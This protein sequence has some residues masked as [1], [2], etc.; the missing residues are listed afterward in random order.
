MSRRI[1]SMPEFSLITLIGVTGAGKTTFCRKRFLPSQAL[2][3]DFFR[4]LVADNEN[5]MEASSDAFETLYSVVEKRLARQLLTVIDATNIQDYA[6]DRILEIARRFDAPTV[7]LVFDVPE[8]VLIKRTILRA[9]RP[10]GEEV[11]LEH[12]VDFRKT[13]Q[14]LPEEG[15]DY[16][17]VLNGVEEVNE[18]V[19]AYS[20][21]SP[22]DNA[23]ERFDKAEMINKST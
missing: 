13:I 10:F 12:L 23:L 20:P 7:A 4:T 17:H 11:V 8:D 19:V 1:I 6:R 3:S 18:A 16:I 22:M 2:S 9:D 5:S 21:H 15:F 14:T